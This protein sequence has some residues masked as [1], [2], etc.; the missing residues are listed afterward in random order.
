MSLTWAIVLLIYCKLPKLY[1]LLL[2]QQS[3]EHF[4]LTFI[5]SSYFSSSFCTWAN[6]VFDF[7]VEEAVIPSESPTYK[8]TNISNRNLMTNTWYVEYLYIPIM[9][10]PHPSIYN[11]THIL[12]VFIKMQHFCN[13][14][15]MTDLQSLYRQECHKLEQ[16]S[17]EQE[18]IKTAIKSHCHAL[19]M[20]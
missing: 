10:I 15:S 19:R 20:S 4:F 7:A 17:H 14:P 11:S 13:L 8:Y 9:H 5:M 12:L 1:K 18:T 6:R 16:G 3:S 2:P